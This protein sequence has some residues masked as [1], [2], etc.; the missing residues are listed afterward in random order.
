MAWASAR[1]RDDGGTRRALDAVDNAYEERSP[2]VVE[3]EWVY[4]LVRTEIDV[5]AGRC[6][7]ELGNPAA[8][9]PLLTNAIMSY[10]T[11]HTREVALHLSWLAEAYARVDTFDA[12]RD[13]LD[14]AS[15][16]AREINSARLDLR[17]RPS[18]QPGSC[19][20]K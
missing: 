15:R 7:I 1:S 8:A 20:V 9:E 16:T 14:Q 17:I 13:A 12:A 4:W 2:G 3:P 11:D 19:Q 10:P 18:E 5:M 6:M